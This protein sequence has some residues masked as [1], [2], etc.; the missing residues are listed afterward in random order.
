MYNLRKIVRRFMSCVTP[1]FIR[2]SLTILTCALSKNRTSHSN[3]SHKFSIFDS[4]EKNVRNYSSSMAW[5]CSANSNSGLV[6]NLKKAGIFQSDRVEQAMKSV[7]RGKYVKYDPYRDSPQ[8]IG[9]GATISAPSTTLM[10]YSSHM[11]A[12]A[13]ENLSPFLRPG[14]KVLDVGCGSGYLTACL[15]E[16]VGPEGKVIGIDHIP[17][18]VNLAKDN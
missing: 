1:T 14:M 2:L 13:L 16:M 18:L 3:I 4:F 11:H 5:F 9:Y 10:F 15:A 8:Q 12:H 6:N 17:Q 7:D